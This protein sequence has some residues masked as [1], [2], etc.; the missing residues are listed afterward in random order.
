MNCVDWVDRYYA[1]VIM[2]YRRRND[3]GELL[4]KSVTKN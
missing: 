2:R 1:A 3:E 4:E